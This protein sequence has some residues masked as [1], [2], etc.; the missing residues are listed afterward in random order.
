MRCPSQYMNVL[1]DLV[2]VEDSACC[3]P[4]RLAYFDGCSL[5]K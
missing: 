2:V 1:G 4:G 3:E 5:Q